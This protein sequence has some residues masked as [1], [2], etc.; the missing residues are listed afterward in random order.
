MPAGKDERASLSMTGTFRD[1]KLEREFRLIEFKS[2]KGK[3]LGFTLVSMPAPFAITLFEMAA[4]G[5]DRPEFWA[6]QAARGF[7]LVALIA[8][9][10]AVVRS[11]SPQVLNAAS[12]TVALA[13]TVPMLVISMLRPEEYMGL[14]LLDI[15]LV[16]CYYLLFP[17][18][19]HLQIVA[20][21]LV[22]CFDILSLF[23]FKN[24]PDPQ[25]Y[26][27]V[28]ASYVA[29]NILGILVSR[30]SN[31]THRLRFL[32]LRTERAL[33]QELRATLDRLQLIEG[34]VP[35]CCHC[36]RIQGDDGEWEE[37]ESFVRRGS[38]VD[39]SHGICPACMDKYYGHIMKPSGSETEK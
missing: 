29:A 37:V 19:F 1:G 8:L 34:I 4:T 10:I 24:P 21:L 6:V 18:P 12:F 3:L 15:V 23:V 20:P 27:V 31:I 2:T 35:I 30:Q 22:S 17:L 7:G 28:P 26:G 11:K 13:F 25:Y 33:A 38:S 36:K 5:A 39:F 14:Y 16:L 9:Y 32:D